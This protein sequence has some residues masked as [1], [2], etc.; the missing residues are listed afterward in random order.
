MLWYHMQDF[1][2]RKA[3]IPGD[4]NDELNKTKTTEYHLSTPVILEVSEKKC[5]CL[6][7]VM[8]KY[9][10]RICAEQIYQNAI[11]DGAFI[12]GKWNILF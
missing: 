4:V 12:C 11:N 8:D 9:H 10:T 3:Y 7:L 5:H 2:L 1:P 6:I